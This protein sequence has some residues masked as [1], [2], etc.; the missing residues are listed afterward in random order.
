MKL[1]IAGTPSSA[2]SRPAIVGNRHIARHLSPD[3]P[4]CLG[5]VRIQR[6]GSTFRR[7]GTALAEPGFQ[8][9]GTHHI[10]AAP[11]FVS[12]AGLPEAD[13]PSA[14]SGIC[15]TAMGLNLD[16]SASF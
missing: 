12:P 6:S 11:P 10:A 7:L 9:L 2:T 13:A 8:T 15:S 5:D 3:A 1:A 16:T 4:V 14:G